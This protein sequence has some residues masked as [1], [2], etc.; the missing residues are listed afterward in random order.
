VRAGAPA[1]T[2]AAAASQA[3][4]GGVAG[5]SVA[6]VAWA[7]AAIVG[8]RTGIGARVTGRITLRT[9]VGSAIASQHLSDKYKTHLVIKNS[10]NL[11]NKK[12]DHD[13]N[14]KLL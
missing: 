4:T 13:D 10:S 7:H 11:H 9:C 5:E 12:D 8:W 1:S 2:A 6:A 3:S 14:N